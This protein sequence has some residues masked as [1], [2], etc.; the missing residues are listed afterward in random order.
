[1]QNRFKQKQI[2]TNKM[3]LAKKEGEAADKEKKEREFTLGEKTNSYFTYEMFSNHVYD[4]TMTWGDLYR[5]FKYWFQFQNW[6]A[7]RATRVFRVAI[8]GLST[9]QMSELSIM[10][11]KKEKDILK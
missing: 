2:H 7:A 10:M 8:G 5:V 11:C 1:M 6:D 3:R 4:G 9:S